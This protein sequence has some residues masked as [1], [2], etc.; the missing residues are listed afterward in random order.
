MK[1]Q[2]P[3]SSSGLVAHILFQLD[4]DPQLGQ[5][6]LHHIEAAIFPPPPSFPSLVENKDSNAGQSWQKLCPAHL[7]QAPAQINPLH[8]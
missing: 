5:A 1:R 7:I 8:K 2:H 4:L 3:L 6:H